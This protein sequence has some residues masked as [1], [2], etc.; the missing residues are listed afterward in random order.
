MSH[1]L[2][3]IINNGFLSTLLG[4]HIGSTRVAPRES[5][6]HLPGI[7]WGGITSSAH[8]S[9]CSSFHP[10]LLLLHISCTAPSDLTLPAAFLERRS[11]SCFKITLAVKIMYSVGVFWYLFVISLIGDFLSICP[12]HEL[13]VHFK[14]LWCC[15]RQRVSVTSLTVSKDIF[16]GSTQQC[17]QPGAAPGEQDGSS[18]GFPTRLRFPLK[19]LVFSYPRAQHFHGGYLPPAH[20]SPS[21]SSHWLL[22]LWGRAA[23]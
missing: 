11:S 20:T 14:T 5:P 10:A 1:H 3:V 16:L 6:W 2:T 18:A 21:S 19:L 15:E 4:V 23:K 7:R 13:C 9:G 17:W 12:I 22:H 8:V